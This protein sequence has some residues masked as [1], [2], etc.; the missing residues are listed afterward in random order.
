MAFHQIFI[1]LFFF[2]VGSFCAE[3][4]QHILPQEYRLPCEQKMPLAVYHY[5]ASDYIDAPTLQAWDS[6]MWPK[7]YFIVQAIDARFQGLLD[8]C[9]HYY[10]CDDEYFENIYRDHTLLKFAPYFQYDKTVISGSLINRQKKGTYR[11]YGLILNVPAENIVATVPFDGYSL[12][13]WQLYNLSSEEITREMRDYFDGTGI[14]QWKFQK[15]LLA[16]AGIERPFLT[17][18]ELLSKTTQGRFNEVLFVPRSSL[19]AEV[20]IVGIFVRDEHILN[21][22][23]F[24]KDIEILKKMSKDLKIPFINLEDFSQVPLDCSEDVCA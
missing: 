10:A 17:P 14:E 12:V 19:G 3:S 13:S 11:P 2:T 9:N 22:Y 18:K 16:D 4:A 5:K 1:S 6:T 24:K 15:K 20:A 21:E 23:F 8:L 7:N